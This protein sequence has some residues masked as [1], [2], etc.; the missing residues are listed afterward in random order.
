MNT[1]EFFGVFEICKEKYLQQ[2]QTGENKKALERFEKWLKVNSNLLQLRAAKEYKNRKIDTGKL[3]SDITEEAMR[4]LSR[5][6]IQISCISLGLKET[7]KCIS[8]FNDNLVYYRLGRTSPRK[9]TYRGMDL[10]LME[11]VMDGNKN[12][13]FIPLLGEIESLEKQIGTK[14][15]RESPKVE[16]TGKYRFKLLF[17]FDNDV[18]NMVEAYARTLA[19]FI[20]YTREKLLELKVS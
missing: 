16:A 17:P 2:D 10:L 1:S 7:S 9:G 11:L 3:F 20:Y 18:E 5:K 15:E 14:I 12:N 19:D 6:G 8:V 4:I 13:V